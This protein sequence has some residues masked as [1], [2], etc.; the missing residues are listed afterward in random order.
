LVRELTQI[1]LALQAGVMLKPH[2]YIKA[3]QH[4]RVIAGPLAD[5]QGIFIKTH[6]NTRLVLK[7]DMLGQATSVEVDADM[8]EPVEN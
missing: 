5:L 8:V 6:S 7:I 2:K 3:G 1:E 4:C